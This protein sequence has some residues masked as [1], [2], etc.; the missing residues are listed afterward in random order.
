MEE[1]EK[2]AQGAKKSIVSIVLLLGLLFLL[3]YSAP[4]L[5]EKL[6][7]ISQQEIA[8]ESAKG[9]ELVGNIEPEVPSVLV[10][11]LPLVTSQLPKLEGEAAK[12]RLLHMRLS[13][14]KEQLL[15][16]LLEGENGDR[17]DV[18]LKR[19]KF[20]RYISQHTDIPLKIYP[21]E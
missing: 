21:P 2:K 11:W 9:D 15:L 6:S 7:E 14:D 10:D 16:D 4:M 12:Y 3:M 13:E 18:I 17:F 8:E 19:D 20:G 1:A 5:Q